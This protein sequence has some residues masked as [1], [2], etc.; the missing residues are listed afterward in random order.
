[1]QKNCLK[2]LCNPTFEITLFNVF[3]KASDEENS[4]VYYLEDCKKCKSMISIKQVE[5]FLK[6][7]KINV[8]YCTEPDKKSALSIVNNIK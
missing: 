3:E 1:M 5:Y 8:D 7:E 6:V 4:L 2:A